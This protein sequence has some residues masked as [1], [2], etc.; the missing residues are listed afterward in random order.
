MEQCVSYLTQIPVGEPIIVPRGRSLIAAGGLGPV[1][2][3]TQGVFKLERQGQDGQILVQLARAGDLIGVES[4]CAEPYAFAAVALV[5]AQVQPHQVSHDL[6]RYATMAQGF[7]QQQRQTCDMHRLR[8]GPIVQRLAHLLTVLGKQADGRVLGFTPAWVMAYAK[9]G[10][11]EQI[12]YNI[13]TQFGDQ[14][15]LIDFKVDRYELDALLTKNWGILKPAWIN[16]NND[17]VDWQNDA[18]TNIPW[19]NNTLAESWIP[20]PPTCTT[21]DLTLVQTV[22]WINNALMTVDW[23]NNSNEV[24]EWFNTFPGSTSTPTI[25]DGGSMQFID[26]VDMYSNSTEY[27]KYLVFPYRTILGQ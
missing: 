4:L 2:C 9:P 27:D 17:L 24:V 11:G 8:T 26:P 13:R 10:K 7:L 14:L 12:A 5:A 18:G 22:S 15:N 19:T 3:V 20:S 25:F 1:W 16:N 21:F 6:D 23:Q